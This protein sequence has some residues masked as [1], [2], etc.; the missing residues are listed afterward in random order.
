VAAWRGRGETKSLDNQI[1]TSNDETIKHR[2]QIALFLCKQGFSLLPL[3][4]ASKTPYMELLPATR[5][6]QASWSLYSL[7]PASESE[8]KDWFIFNPNCNYGILTGPASIGGLYILDVDEPEKLP[9]E[10]LPPTVTIKTGRGYHY[11]FTSRK[12]LNGCSFEFGELKGDGGYIVGPGSE[13]ENGALY[14]FVD[15]LGPADVEIE[16]LPEWLLNSEAARAYEPMPALKEPNKTSLNS[17]N[18][19][20]IKSKDGVRNNTVTCPISFEQLEQLNQ[21]PE[22]AFKIM[23]LCGREV[24]RIGKA[25]TC[26]LPGHSERNPSAALYHEPGRPI[27]LNDFHERKTKDEETGEVKEGRFSWPLV[28]VYASCKIGKALQLKKGERAIW[29]LRALHEIG[30]VNPPVL[31]R[32]NLPVDAKKHVLK[33]YDGFIYLM[34][35]R[36]LYAPQDSA[37][38]SWSFAGRWCGLKSKAQV[39][40]GMKY[41]IGRGYLYMKQAGVKIGEGEGPRSALFAI[42]RPRPERQG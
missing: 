34:E 42:G 39:E 19:K 17:Q 10:S 29:W 32:Y 26:P 8:V 1:I 6:G 15:M 18:S 2:Q 3:K 5:T 23:A 41:L 12:E 4:P 16:E 37:P 25:F 35:L 40:Q 13:H 11:Y 30:K 38:F 36:Q 28:D 9:K 20:S 7:R 14:S 27:I 31:N 33:L 21:E 24:N 22:T